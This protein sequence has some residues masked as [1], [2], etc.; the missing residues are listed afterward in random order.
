MDNMLKSL[1]D[2]AISS[3][4][5]DVIK[6]DSNKAAAASAKI[7][8]IASEIENSTTQLKGLATDIRNCW[9]GESADNFVKEIYML[10]L[11]T[12]TIGE[13]VR[14][15]SQKLDAAIEIFGTADKKVRSD[16][17]SLPVSSAFKN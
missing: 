2:G 4:N 15:N 8:T 6:F 5:G 16:V 14:Q 12:R 3:V 1:I 13:K 10:N 9:T 7:R 17:E 11:E